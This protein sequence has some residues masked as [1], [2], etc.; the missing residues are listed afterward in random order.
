MKGGGVLQHQG[1]G[2]ELQVLWAFAVH[3]K[4]Q[5]ESALHSYLLLTSDLSP[6][7]WLGVMGDEDFL[8]RGCQWSHFL[9][10]ALQALPTFLHAF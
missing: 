8:K 4:L 10:R 6:S 3:L 9:S 5:R 7:L 1:A 2:G